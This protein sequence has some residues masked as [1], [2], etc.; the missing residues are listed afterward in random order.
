M[1][2]TEVIKMRRVRTHTKTWDLLRR[3]SLEE[4]QKA[5][6]DHGIYKAAKELGC[7][8]SIIRYLALRERWKRILPPHLVKAYN[9]GRWNNFRTNFKPGSDESL[10]S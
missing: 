2:E 6:Y 5:H 10:K 9:A 4:V 7:D 1:A 8:P 3:H